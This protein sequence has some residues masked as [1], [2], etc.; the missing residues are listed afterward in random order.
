MTIAKIIENELDGHGRRSVRV[1]YTFDD[2]TTTILGRVM[3]L[4][5]VDAQVW[6]DGHILD[7]EEIKADSE[8]REIISD[9]ERR[10]EQR[11]RE[12][13]ERAS[14][15]EQLPNTAFAMLRSRLNEYASR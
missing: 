3:L 6:A 10:A 8:Q 1:K 9:F 5:T 15:R 7:Q 11:F 14:N 2:A 13:L 4:E 12:L